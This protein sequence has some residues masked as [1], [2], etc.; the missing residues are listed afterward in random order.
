MLSCKPLSHHFAASGT[1][2]IETARLLRRE[3]QPANILYVADWSGSLV[4]FMKELHIHYLGQ[5]PNA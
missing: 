3:L 2:H 1:R 5:V 4:K